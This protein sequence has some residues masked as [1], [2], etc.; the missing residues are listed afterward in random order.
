MDANPKPHKAA[1]PEPLDAIVLAGT[2]SNP[3]RMIQGQNKAFLEIGGRPLVREVVEALLAAESIGDVYVVGPRDRLDEALRE[4]GAVVLLDGLDEVP[5]PG[6][7]IRRG[8]EEGGVLGIVV[9]IGETSAGIA[10][11]F[12][13]TLLAAK[14]GCKLGGWGCLVFGAAGA[15]VGVFGTQKVYNWSYDQPWE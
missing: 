6:R 1:Y 9:E 8:A 3:R 14:I 2:D 4:G 13:G 11:G 15:A 12:A 5:D 7:E 10:G